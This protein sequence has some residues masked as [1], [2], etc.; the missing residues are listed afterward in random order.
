MRYPAALLALTFLAFLLAA[1]GGGSG[2]TNGTPTAA[3]PITIALGTTAPAATVE[4]TAPPEVVVPNTGPAAEIVLPEGFT[5]YVIASDFLRT[6]TIALG[7]DG[8]LY[9]SE[10]HGNVYRE[11]DANGDGI[12]EKNNLFADGFDDITGLLVAPDGAVLVSSTGKVTLLRDTDGDGVADQRSEIVSDLPTGRHQNNGLV[13]GTDGKIYL[14]LGSTCDDC[15]EDDERSATILQMNPDGS[16]LR[17]YATGLR[18]PYDLVFDSQGRLWATDNGSDIPCETID[19]LDFIVDG[20]DYGWPYGE[21]GCDPYQ[22]GIPPAAD[23]G[24]HTAATGVTFYEAAH[25]PA[26]YQGNLFA[27]VWGSF[28]AEPDPY[29]RV[30]LAIAIEEVPGGQPAGAV[31]EFASGFLHP[32]DLLVDRDGTL[33]VLDYGGDDPEERTGKLYRIIY[34]GE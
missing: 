30:L 23:L 4:P 1:C 24:L 33:L 7:P 15:V 27:T 16:E 32:I 19:E 8:E 13:L 3:P 20:G 28:F 10:R 25:F 9:V 22:D 18:N 21:D 17:V 6:S 12:F 14:T 26:Q 29:D 31:E 5:A 34:T 2:G 11:E